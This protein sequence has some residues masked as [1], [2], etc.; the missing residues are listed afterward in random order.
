MVVLL[1]LAILL[2]IAIP[3]F[4][5][6]S[7]NAD[8]RAAQSN[9]NIALTTAKAS[10]SQNN[11]T[12]AGTT[13]NRLHANEPSIVFGDSSNETTQGP[14]SD[15]VSANGDG[16]VLA[17]LSLNNK[18]C[19]YTVDNL[20]NLPTGAGGAYGATQ[21]LTGNPTQAPSAAGSWYSSESSAATCNAGVAPTGAAGWT[22]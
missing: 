9:L 15:Y 2:A 1:I 22:S 6:V 14:V 3:T 19:W 17:S 20:T 16:V 4:L 5:G 18:T 8:D 7:E 10:E 13:A 11:Q 12:F 21:S